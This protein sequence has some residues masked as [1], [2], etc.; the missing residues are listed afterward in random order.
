MKFYAVGVGPGDPE[1]I[2]LAALRTLREAGL[3]VVPLS[4]PGKESEAERIVRRHLP[5]APIL[6]IVFPMVRDEARR[7]AE[8]RAQL[9]T[10]RGRWES[11]PSVVMPVIGDSALYATAFWLAK[12]W[13][14]LTDVQ[15]QLVPGVSAHS[16]ACCL[17][18]QFLAMG[19]DV[20]SVIPG[21]AAEERIT[22]ALRACDCA[23]LYKPSALK[24]RLRE[25]VASAGPWR[26]VIR[27]D[28]AGLDGQK[29]VSGPEA[30]DEASEYLS[31]LLLWR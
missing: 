14:Q 20:F 26:Q 16:L 24:G 2:T 10:C 8:L 12:A 3:I 1:L 25:I 21:T 29:I 13:S 28:R 27:V 5:D 30:L 18:G 11:V 17:T 15:L 9:E 22:E 23:A 7:D 4:A 6:Q 31:T 19:D